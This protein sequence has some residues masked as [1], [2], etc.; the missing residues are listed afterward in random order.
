M[1]Q[2]DKPIQIDRDPARDAGKDLPREQAEKG[3]SKFDL[4]LL[5]VQKLLRRGAITNLTKMLGKT[6]PADIAKLIVHLPSPKEKRTVFELVK[7]EGPR[8]QVLSE[9]DADSIQH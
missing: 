1:Q 3:Q 5:S 9:M 6:H 8:G 7:G 2:S 4:V